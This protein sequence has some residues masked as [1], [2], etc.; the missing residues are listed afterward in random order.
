MTLTEFLAPLSGGSQREACLAVLYYH[1]RHR[2]KPSL[3]VEE[4]RD[5]LVR[6]RAPKASKINVADVLKLRAEL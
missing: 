1:Q 4:I 5:E 6:A 2:D 3:T